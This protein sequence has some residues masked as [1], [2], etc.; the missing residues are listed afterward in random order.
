MLQMYLKMFQ[1]EQFRKKAEAT[2]TLIGN[3]V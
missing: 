3:E 2:G 1:K